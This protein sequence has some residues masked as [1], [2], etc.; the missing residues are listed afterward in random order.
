MKN[1]DTPCDYCATACP[2]QLN[3][4]P[5]K[6][7]NNDHSI[8]KK[9]LIVEKVYLRNEVMKNI[10]LEICE[11]AFELAVLYNKFTHEVEFGYEVKYHEFLL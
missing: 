8:S 9:P 5:E 6:K 1:T 3:S 4:D 11:T 10:N 2:L 7:F